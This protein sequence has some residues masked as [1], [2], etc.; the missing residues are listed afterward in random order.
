MIAQ[1]TVGDNLRNIR[2]SLG[3]TQGEAASA[4]GISGSTISKIELGKR[5]VNSTELARIANLYHKTVSELL[6][7]DDSQEQDNSAMRFRAKGMLKED[8]MQVSEFRDLC[9]RY[10]VLER[11]VY[12]SNRL[13]IPLYEK[14][15]ER[16]RY[17]ER[18]DYAEW[19][20]R[21]ERDRLQLGSAPIKSMFSLLDGQGVKV[22]KLPL[23]QK[24]SGAFLHT[25]DIGPCVLINA[26]HGAR[27]IYTA[28]HEYYH[29][30]VDRNDFF[31]ICED[32]SKQ[33]SRTESIEEHFAACFLM[34]NDSVS[35]QY[36]KRFG[37][38]RS[39]P[40]GYDILDLSREFH[41][42]YSAMLV[43][44]KDLKL[45]SEEY[46]GKLRASSPRRMD[47]ERGLPEIEIDK[48]ALPSKYVDM[49]LELYFREEISIGKL[50]EYL[51]KSIPEAQKIAKE[52][53][54]QSQ[55]IKGVFGIAQA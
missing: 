5:N 43:R 9:K 45:L 32:E 54:T 16:L 44:L 29:C 20:A 4:L 6:I 46:Y 50:A 36:S 24:F 19:L 37:A 1:K 55:V 23:S 47:E 40:G 2:K 49:A 18:R 14:P 35:Q 8:R 13:K 39:V 26:N 52:R 53:R 22:F 31:L 38:L 3:M 12:E 11:R 25:E 30:L 7:P 10:S 48:S 33:Q 34:P 27:M 21:R 17:N 41:V 42:S 15:Y 51:K 28:A